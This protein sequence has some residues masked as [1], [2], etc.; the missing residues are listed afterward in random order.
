M[1]V[2]YNKGVRSLSNT[3]GSGYTHL[4]GLS[5]QRV[6]GTRRSDL[7]LVVDHVSQTL[8]VHT[9]KVDVRL[10]FFTGN[11]RIHWFIPVKVVSGSPQLLAEV[12][13]RGVGIGESRNQMVS[14][15][16]WKHAPR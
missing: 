8:I 14:S 6:N 2:K 15:S 9:S 1:S 11:P 12:I 16:V 7:E 3:R 5:G 13:H 4:D 10:E